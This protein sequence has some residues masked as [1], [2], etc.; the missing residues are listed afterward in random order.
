[1]HHHGVALAHKGEQSIQLGALRVF[2]G[3]LVRERAGHLDAFQLPIRVLIKAAD[4]DIADAL[5]IHVF[6]WD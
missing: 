6:S 4:A 3:G 1:M 5:T 2:A